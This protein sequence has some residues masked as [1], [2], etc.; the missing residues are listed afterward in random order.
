MQPF[1]QF[2]QNCKKSQCYL[3]KSEAGLKSAQP[4]IVVVFKQKIKQPKVVHSISVKWQTQLSCRSKIYNSYIYKNGKRVVN[5][6][7]EK[8]DHCAV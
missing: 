6:R 2:N 1:N 8:T 7:S 5:G 3:H 4:G